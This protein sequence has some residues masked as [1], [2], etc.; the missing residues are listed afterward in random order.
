MPNLGGTGPAPPSADYPLKNRHTCIA[1]CY[2][3]LQD[4]AFP[5]EYGR[6]KHTLEKQ[7]FTLFSL[8]YSHIYFHYTLY[9]Y[10]KGLNDLFMQHTSHYEWL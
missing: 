4:T 9:F 2:L 10:L 5:I 6:W 3:R 7:P 1:V 8:M